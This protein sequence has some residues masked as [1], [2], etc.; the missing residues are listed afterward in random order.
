MAVALAVAATLAF[1]EEAVS[2]VAAMVA[3]VVGRDFAE[4]RAVSEVAVA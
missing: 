4:E 2:E 3:S 1:S